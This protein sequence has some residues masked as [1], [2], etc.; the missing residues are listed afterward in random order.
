MQGQFQ[1][2]PTLVSPM[3]KCSIGKRGSEGGAAHDASR[4]RTDRGPVRALGRLPL[5][6]LG[7]LLL[8][9]ALTGCRESTQPGLKPDEPQLIATARA[10]T[11]NSAATDRAALI[12]FYNTTD[13]PNWTESSAW[14]S[15]APIGEWHGVTADGNGRVARL[16]LQGNQLKGEIPQELGNLAN[17]T[18]LNL[19]YNQLTG[20]I[21]TELG[22]LTNLKD[23]WISDNQLKGEIPQELGNLANLTD[24]NLS[25]NQ[26]TGEIPTELSGPLRT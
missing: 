19:S 26:L 12:K 2:L 10:T 14:M 23:L 3:N 13:G 24:L 5:L 21:P 11:P 6:V 1:P 25:Y 17:L 15:E 16:D 22:G 9:G 20:E 7:A 8:L 4:R 18:F